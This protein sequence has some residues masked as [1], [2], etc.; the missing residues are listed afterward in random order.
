[1]GQNDTW[2]IG[3]STLPRSNVT[4]SSLQQYCIPPG[5]RS[6]SRESEGKKGLTYSKLKPPSDCNKECLDE[7]SFFLKVIPG[8]LSAIPFE[9][10]FWNG[11]G[12]MIS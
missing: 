11:E 1:M 7:L 4:N 5:Q 9:L 12:K 8:R 3:I 2:L 6:R 10:S